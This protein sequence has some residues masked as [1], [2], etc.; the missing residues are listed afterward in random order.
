MTAV[1]VEAPRPTRT[2]RSRARSAFDRHSNAGHQAPWLHVEVRRSASGAP[3][4][5]TL[6]SQAEIS[7]RVFLSEGASTLFW[8]VRTYRLVWLDH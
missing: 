1:P 8:G 6:R 3:Y 7:Q 2:R 5:V 4:V